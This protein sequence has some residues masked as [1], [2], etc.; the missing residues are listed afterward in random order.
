MNILIEATGSLTSYYL[1]KSI[2]DAGFRVIGSD[3]NDDNHAKFL[4]DDFIIMPTAN[5]KSLWEIIPSLLRKHNI[6]MVL[7][8]FDETL[9]DWSAKK[10]IMKEMGINVIVSPIETIKIFQDKWSAYKFFTEIQIP[11]PKTSLDNIYSLIKPRQGRGGKGI[12]ENEKDK[13]ISMDGLISQEKIIGDE[14]TVDVLFSRNHR[15][16]YIV[17]RKRLAVIDGKSTKGIVVKNGKIDNLIRH[18]AEKVKFIGP[19]NFQ[20]FDTGENLIVIEINPRIAGGM[21]LGFAA[22]ENWITLIVKNIVN[23]EEINPVPIKYGL[24]MVRYYNECFF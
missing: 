17:P 6:N 15:P 20:L 5:D 21:A 1:I 2:K 18:V 10:D 8:S 22:T 19:I 11:T 12:F 4:C 7:P 13:V 9:L 24:Q 3:I 14:Y 23:G 16:I